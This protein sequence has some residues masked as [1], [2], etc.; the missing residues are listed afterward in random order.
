M[1]RDYV[2]EYRF[3]DS[4]Y[5][6]EE[7]EWDATTLYKEVEKQGVKP[8][9]F[10]LSCLNMRIRRFRWVENIADISHHAKRIELADK[11]IPIIL[12]PEGSILDGYHRICRALIDCDSHIMAYR[13]DEMPKPDRKSDGEES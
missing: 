3:T 6:D 4:K 9:R 13:L 10:P 11:S 12:C 5:C 7:N 2:G 8:F 1:A